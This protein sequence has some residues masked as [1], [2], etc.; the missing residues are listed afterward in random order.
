M[1]R[2]RIALLSALS[3]ASFSLAAAAHPTARNGSGF[4]AG[5]FG[6]PKETYCNDATSGT[7]QTIEPRYLLDRLQLAAQCHFTLVIEPPR[8]GL[9]IT[10]ANRGAFSVESA[11][12]LMDEYAQV[13]TPDVVRTY[14]GTI[15]GF[16]LGDDY[17]CPTCWG[18]EKVTQAQIAAWAAYAR[19]RIPGLPLG[20]RGTPDWVEKDPSLAPLLDYVWAQYT[21]QDGDPQRYY[22]EA[23]RDAQKM[24]LQIVMGINVENCGGP[25]TD[26]CTAAE[27]ERVG[28]I[29]VTH[30]ASCAFLNWRYDAATWEQ[31]D[32]EAAWSGLMAKAEA[33]PRRDCRRVLQ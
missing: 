32:I 5:F 24:G 10:G 21:T 7:V 33:R 18:D 15:L 9:T 14:S 31:P 13:L 19:N 29:A 20:V 26:P 25:H 3:L 23:A 16:N 1:S 17:N 12:R 4:I 2:M 27:L 6:W 11:E 8:K 22:D 28:G 30:P